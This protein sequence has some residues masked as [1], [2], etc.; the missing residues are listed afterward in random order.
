M[1][2]LRILVVDDEK[3]PRELLSHFLGELGHQIDSAEDADSAIAKIAAVDYDAVLTDKRMP[4]SGGPGEAAG[5][6]VL[7]FSAENAPETQVIITTGYPDLEDAVSAMQKGAFDYLVKPFPLER[8]EAIIERLITLK[9]FLDPQGMLAAYRGLRQEMLSG[10]KASSLG[11]REGHALLLSIEEKIDE[12]FHARKR[13]E[14]IIFDQR[15]SLAQIA[16][17]AAML[18]ERLDKAPPGV[19]ELLEKISLIADHRL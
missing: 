11:N 14:N 16:M 5:L 3:E 19:T 12:V 6:R 17:Y 1:S 4:D 7:K 13:L 9:S 10:L 8:L 2:Q 15:D 18:H